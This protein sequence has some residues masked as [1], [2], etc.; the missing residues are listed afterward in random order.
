MRTANLASADTYR[1]QINTAHAMIWVSHDLDQIALLQTRVDELTR[2]MK[3]QQYLAS[4][5]NDHLPVIPGL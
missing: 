2:L 3:E 1:M 4:R 5:E